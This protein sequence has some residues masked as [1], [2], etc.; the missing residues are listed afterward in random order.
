MVVYVQAAVSANP[1][2]SFSITESCRLHLRGTGGQHTSSF[3]VENDA[4]AG[5]VMFDAAA[6][7]PH[8]AH[9]FWVSFDNQATWEFLDVSIW[10]EMTKAGF[11]SGAVLWFDHQ[12]VTTS[13]RQ[14]T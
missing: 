5:T 13:G 4:L 7:G 14:A 9:L 8:T 2:H 10:K 3:G 6:A 11:T 12:V 1:L